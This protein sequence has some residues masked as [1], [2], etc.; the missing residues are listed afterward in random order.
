VLFDRGA[1]V[2]ADAAQAYEADLAL[3]FI[4]KIYRATLPPRLLD[5]YETFALIYLRN[6]PKIGINT[7]ITPRSRSH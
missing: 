5:K 6:V 2:A 4:Y 1:G 7:T 3:Q